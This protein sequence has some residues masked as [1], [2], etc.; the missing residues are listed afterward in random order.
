MK[1][2]TFLLLVYLTAATNL[3]AQIYT[4][5]N[6]SA[7]VGFNGSIGP[8]VINN[9][10]WF[11][12]NATLST[13][14]YARA[15]LFRNDGTGNIDLGTLGGNNSI[16]YD[17][18]DFNVVVGFAEKAG[19]ISRA[20]IFSG[21]G[22]NNI[23]LG[24]LDIL[25]QNA[26]SVATSINNARIVVGQSTT[27][28]GLYHATQFSETSANIDLGT[29]PGGTTSYAT[30]INIYGTIV[31][32]ANGTNIGSHATKFSGSGSGNTD[33]GTLGGVTSIAYSIND[34]GQI[35]GVADTPFPGGSHAARFTSDGPQDLG[36]LGGKNSRAIAI[37][38]SGDIV[39]AADLAGNY[40]RAFIIH[41]SGPM[42]DLN[43]L[44]P[45]N[46]GVFLYRAISIND[47]GQI[48]IVGNNRST[49]R[50]DPANTPPPPIFFLITTSAQPPK[51]GTV[52]QSQKIE[53]GGKIT[54]TAQPKRGF[55]FINW[56]EGRKIVSRKKNYTFTV[57]QARTLVAH[58]K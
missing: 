51:K 22:S 30:C 36:T 52:S 40:E 10:G 44:I 45:A 29:L 35:V 15:N 43:T 31:G 37:N 38:N 18:N 55:K 56:T 25:N 14:S 16:P 57:S 50:L 11:A 28:N 23:N 41:G 7:P 8:V 20:V 34:S 39:G 46:S 21:T 12:S 48:L 4:V 13:S 17:I 2:L 33:L 26:T 3:H 54:L 24:T 19:N 32:N 6:L 27:P 58:F 49:Y 1:R 42:L 47:L 9:N 5:T 53:V